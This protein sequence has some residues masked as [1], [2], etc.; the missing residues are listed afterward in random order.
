MLSFL[1]YARDAMMG[2]KRFPSC[3]PRAP[4]LNGET[5]NKSMK[6]QNCVKYKQGQ[7][8]K[9]PQNVVST[10]QGTAPCFTISVDFKN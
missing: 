9:I 5:G 2:K 6:N 8:Q 1:Q 10:C 4:D 3:L 7:I